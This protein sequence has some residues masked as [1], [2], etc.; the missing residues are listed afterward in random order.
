MSSYGYFLWQKNCFKC[1]LPSFAALMQFAVPSA[2]SLKRF[3]V[4]D[5]KEL[6]EQPES[7]QTF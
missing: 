7:T 1:F 5:V 2:V 3:G 6:P 4:P